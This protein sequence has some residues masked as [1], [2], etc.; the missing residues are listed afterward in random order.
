NHLE[1]G[2]LSR[3][4]DIAVAANDTVYVMDGH[5]DQVIHYTAKGKFIQA[6]GTK[7]G[8]LAIA[9]NG[10]VYVADY[11]NH[12]IQQFTAQGNFIR[13]W[14]KKGF[15]TE[16]Q[17]SG[18]QDI[19]IVPDG[20]V[21]IMN[22]RD[23][24]QFSA[25]GDFIQSFDSDVFLS[26]IDIA[27]DGSIYISSS[28]FHHSI[29]HLSPQ[30]QLIQEWISAGKA[31][32]QFDEPTDIALSLDEKSLYVADQNN[33]RIKKFDTL[34]NL[35]HTWGSYGKLQGQFNHPRSIA[36]APDHSVYVLG[37]VGRIQQFTEQGQFIRSW[38]LESSRSS[39]DIAV[40]PDGSVY[41]L[42]KAR[43]SSITINQV[44]Q[45]TA[46]GQLIRSWGKSGTKEGEL[47]LPTNIVIADD[48]SI[49]IYDSKTSSV[50]KFNAQG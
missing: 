30:G 8:R 50:Q 40:A 10:D 27:S 38:E 14:G 24:H 39:R 16:N 9:S 48:G 25:Q 22:S 29:R 43:N 49:Y 12:R 44:Q 26:A 15:Y 32:D 33:H 37:M 4:R 46:Q 18:P 6:W 23:I 35:L 42:S 1:G 7:G 21:Y 31:L 13:S 45:F 17:S 41:V 3:P 47:V 5:N 2:R 28:A 34:G 36:V 20:K 11:E 19:A